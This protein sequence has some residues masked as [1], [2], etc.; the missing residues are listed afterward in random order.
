MTDSPQTDRQ[1]ASDIGS[2]RGSVAMGIVPK[3]GER[4]RKH[5]PLALAIFIS[6]VLLGCLFCLGLLSGR[7]QAAPEQAGTIDVV[8][9]IGTEQGFCSS[10]Q[11]I[12]VDN[13]T[14]VYF[15]FT[16]TNLTTTTLRNHTFALPFLGITN[17]FTIAL[18]PNESFAI[19]SWALSDLGVPVDLSTRVNGE[20]ASTV[21]VTSF[22][23]EGVGY[24]GQ[25]SAR[26]LIGQATAA[27][28]QTVGT[29]ASACAETESV[30]V[31]NGTTISYCVTITKTGTLDFVRHEI[32]A[33]QLGTTYVYTPPNPALTPLQ[34]NAQQ[35]G[36]TENIAGPVTNTITVTSYTAE[37]ATTQATA[38]ARAVPGQASAALTYTV[39]LNAP[40][41]ATTNSLSVVV[42]T[43]V[44]YCIKLTNTGTVP[45]ERHAINAPQLSFQTTLTETV[46]PSATLIITSDRYSQLT[47]IINTLDTNNIT[48]NSYTASDVLVSNQATATVNIGT[49]AIGLTKYALRDGSNCP[50]TGSLT[51]MAGDEFY[52]CVIVRNNGA[53]PLTNFTISEPFLGI[54]FTFS[55]ELTQNQS[56]TLTNNFLANTLQ[57]NTFLGPF[58]T[59]RS[60]TPAM[61]IIGQTASG[62][63]TQSSSSFQII[64]QTPTNTPVTPATSTPTWTP[65]QTPVPTTT[66]TPPPTF[67]PTNVVISVLPTPTDPFNLGSVATP[68]ANGIPG[69]GVAPTSPLATS[70]LDAPPSPLD[71]PTPTV[72]FVATDT[73]ATA[74]AASV[75]AAAAT[76]AFEFA[77]TQTAVVL[78]LTP[79]PTATETPTPTSPPT[80]TPS[81]TATATE[82]AVPAIALE[83]P[84]AESEILALPSNN[85]DIN[86]YLALFLRTLSISTA[87]LGWLWFLMGSIIFFAVAGMF[88]GLSFRQRE[89][90][91]YDAVDNTLEDPII[92]DDPSPFSPTVLTEDDLYTATVDIDTMLFTNPQEHEERRASRDTQDQTDDPIDDDFWPASLR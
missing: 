61:T 59:N 86:D 19:N 88:A 78:S 8:Y 77:A 11:V 65:S 76:V 41:C 69:D 43:T 74:A 4:D 29:N 62:S 72:D 51:L 5:Q 81:A 3:G 33:P 15:C 84:T 92:F 40:Q 91:R 24:S 17:T 28:R 89:L 35:T 46:A 79:T 85:G 26:V 23:E 22:D 25:S 6:S 56:I 52:Y 36:L 44:Y 70:P 66:P 53:V 87:T 9:T 60:I 57:I 49:L 80:A 58:R 73:A 2:V 68:T 42:G 71:T 38:T 27:V 20:I 12:A 34:L 55:Y 13:G 30:A 32:N 16:I 39:G 64:A 67:T 90:S 10:E 21:T 54:D 50:V 18:G 37:G 48:I 7:L 82:T 31:P 45:L 83:T 1:N 47:K 63:T 14:V 75:T